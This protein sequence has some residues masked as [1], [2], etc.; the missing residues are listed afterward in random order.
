[1]ANMP[2]SNDVT[3]RVAT[4]LAELQGE[5]SDAEMAD[6]L[7]VSRPYYWSLKNGKR[8][9]SYA[10]MKRAASIWPEIALMVVRDVA[11]G[12]GAA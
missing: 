2:A 12:K 6:L 7:D 3:S 5:R 9:P 4:K 8:R 11:D 1:M 10:L